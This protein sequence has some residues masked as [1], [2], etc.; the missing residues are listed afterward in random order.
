MAKRSVFSADKS[1]DFVANDIEGRGIVQTSQHKNPPVTPSNPHIIT[2]TSAPEP[3]VIASTTYPP[4]LSLGVGPSPPLL[5]GAWDSP[6]YASHLAMMHSSSPSGPYPAPHALLDHSL[7]FSSHT[8]PNSTVGP[9]DITSLPHGAWDSPLSS[10]PVTIDYCP[11]S[12]PHSALSTFVLDCNQSLLT[13]HALADGMANPLNITSE[14]YGE[15]SEAARGL[16]PPGFGGPTTS[17]SHAVW[18][19]PPF[20]STTVGPAAFTLVNSDSSYTHLHSATSGE[21]IEDYP[22]A[23]QQCSSCGSPSSSA[24]I[25]GTYCFCWGPG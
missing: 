14:P 10:H 12:S 15:W 9:S 24:F 3:Q 16:C 1:L 20:P 5:H 18:E 23:I 7:S 25:T 4:C 22:Q 11:S 17:P 21:P 13:S 19:S 2:A 8:P 6:S